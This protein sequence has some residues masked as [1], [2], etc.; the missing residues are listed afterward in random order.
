MREE[1]KAHF[2]NVLQALMHLNFTELNTLTIELQTYIKT[3]FLIWSHK[4]L[5]NVGTS[6]QSR[7][8]IA[9]DL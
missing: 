7:S 9:L 5:E 6:N 3:S 2:G 8:Y 4:E 1:E